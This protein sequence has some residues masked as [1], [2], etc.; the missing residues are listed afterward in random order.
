MCVAVIKKA[1]SPLPDAETLK[2]CWE[3]NRDG[4]G[5]AYRVPGGI[6]ILKGFMTLE[7]FLHAFREHYYEMKDTDCF[8]HFRIATAGG[9][10]SGM[11]HPFPVSNKSDG[12]KSTDI[13]ASKVMMH[14]GILPLR[15]RSADWSDSAELSAIL[16]EKYKSVEQEA[17]LLTNAT[18]NSSNKVAVMDSEGIRTYGPWTEH[19]G[20][21]FSNMLWE[22]HQE[23]RTRWP[24]SWWDDDDEEDMRR[25]RSF[26]W[27]DPLYCPGYKEG[28]D[29]DW[30]SYAR[31]KIGTNDVVQR[32]G[33]Y[34]DYR[35]VTL[36]DSDNMTQEMTDLLGE[37]LSSVCPRCGRTLSFHRDDKTLG[38][39]LR[40][41]HHCSLL[42]CVVSE[43]DEVYQRCP[44]CGEWQGLTVNETDY[45]TEFE[46]FDCGC[47]W[48]EDRDISSYIPE[49]KEKEKEKLC[50][51]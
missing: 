45:E 47:T 6:R 18:L 12:L 41:C 2:L 25:E 48:V 11:T 42:F 38:E 17:L 7:S 13:V 1:G 30:M 37:V 46:C 8:F 32:A 4:A 40:A 5:M 15:P 27:Q 50:A 14:N 44:V 9:V 3:A 28:S 23:F 33:K 36:E 34:E 26:R 43:Y 24:S 31:I 39:G 20:L 51:Y 49:L 29:E 21:L 35:V 22:Y 16:A 10:Y 19:K